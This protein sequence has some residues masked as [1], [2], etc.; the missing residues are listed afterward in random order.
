M[1]NQ[2]AWL[3]GTGQ[4]FRVGSAEMPNIDAN[5]VLIKNCAIAINPIDWKVRDYGWL[6]KHWPTILGS[7]AAGVVIDVGSEVHNFKKGDRVI[8]HGISMISQKPKHGTFQ[9]YVAFEAPKVA[10]IPDSMSFNDACVLPLAFDT[11][12]TGL[13]KDHDKGYLGLEFPSISANPSDKK[14]IIYGGSSSVGALA[15]QLAVAAGAYVV[16]IA[17]RKNFDFCRSCGAHEVF[18]YNDPT[19]VDEVVQAVKSG[20]PTDFVGIFDTI[21]QEESYKIVVP[22]LERLGSGNLATVLGGPSN[23]PAGSKTAYVEGIN[24]YVDLLR[25]K[26]MTPALE[27]GILK[28]LPKPFVVGKGLESVE[29]G[30][31]EN[32]KGVSAKKVV[33]ELEVE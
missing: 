1:T 5:E 2:A 30:C 6:I 8:G 15:I 16:A 32:K 13:F 33:I 11:A 12:A 7:D 4:T 25:G 9:H 18:D 24:D 10:K 17:S 27:Q 20:K 28:C 14:L 3:D 23:L 31:L 21:S 26:F 22:I 29:K 19:V